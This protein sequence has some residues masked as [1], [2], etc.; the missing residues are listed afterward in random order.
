MGVGHVSEA[1][2][3]K[4]EHLARDKPVV[5]ATRCGRGPVLRDTYGYRGAEKDLIARGLEPAGWLDG[6][7]SRLALM[8]IGVANLPD[9]RHHFASI[10]ES[11]S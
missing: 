11:V 10:R 7:T 8:A 9:W 3:E 6:R 2:A 1:W 4:L 5:F